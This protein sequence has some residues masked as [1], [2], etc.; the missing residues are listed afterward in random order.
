MLAKAKQLFAA[1]KLE[2]ERQRELDYLLEGLT[3]HMFFVRAAR[4]Q[5]K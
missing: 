1:W 2:R 3:N 5:A 4:D